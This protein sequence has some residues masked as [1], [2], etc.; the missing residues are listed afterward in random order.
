[1]TSIIGDGDSS[2]GSVPPWLW[3]WVVLYVL[4]LPDNI[5]FYGPAIVDLFFHKDWLVLVNVPELLP[6]LALFGGVLLILFPWLRVFYLERQFQLAEP[7]R[8]SSAL[9]EM[10]T[11]LQQHAPGIHIK[12]NMLRTDQLAFVYP[13]GYRKTGIA[14][15]G[16]LF[17]L[18]RSDKQTAEAI[19]LHEVAH[20]RHGDALIIGVG[21][22]F[23]VVVRNFIVLYLLFCFLPL[24]WSFASQSIDVLQ[25]GI[26]FAYKLQQIFTIILPGSFLQLL[27]LL[28]GLAS[29]FVLPIIA[30]WGAE[31]NADRFVINQQKSSFDLLQALNKIS[32]PLSIF[33]WIIFRLTHPPTKMRKWAA[34]PRLGKFLLVLLLFPVA[35]FAKLLALVIRALSGYLP[36]YSDFAGIF[37]QLADNIETYFAAIAPIWCTMA[38]FFLLWPFMSM[39]WE[40]YFGGSRGAQSFGTYAAY[41]LSALLVGLPALLWIY[42]A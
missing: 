20:C 25:S 32:L 36:I 1:M 37:V 4:S 21:S 2:E 29:V 18:W 16:S 27:G 13:L 15:F 19:L 11:F 10:E 12:T 26:P 39:Y 42:L 8:N 34:E 30:I 38:G 7:D 40:Q 24:S 33:S 28:G 17:R 31:F 9:T 41:L 3:F 22:F 14:L 6:F 35:Y 23:E 5:R